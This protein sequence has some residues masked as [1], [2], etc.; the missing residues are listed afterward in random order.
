[1]S[2]SAPSSHTSY[3]PHLLQDNVGQSWTG[4]LPHLVQIEPPALLSVS[5]VLWNVTPVDLYIDSG[6]EVTVISESV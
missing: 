3:T 2:G 6:A 4:L 5:L 1:M